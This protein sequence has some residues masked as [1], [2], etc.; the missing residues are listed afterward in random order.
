MPNPFRKGG[1]EARVDRMDQAIFRI[2][3]QCYPALATSEEIIHGVLR[4][5]G[6]PDQRGL[7]FTRLRALLDQGVV[8]RYDVDTTTGWSLRRQ[9]V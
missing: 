1:E 6:S 3:N 7:V 8:A 4:S 2:L 5:E 9:S